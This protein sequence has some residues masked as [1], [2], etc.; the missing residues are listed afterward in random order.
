MIGTDMC[1]PMW[2]QK[3]ENV[4]WRNIDSEKEEERGREDT[5]V[6]RAY[7]RGS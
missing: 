2:T 3:E 7:F 5:Q 6:E 1:V 4:W